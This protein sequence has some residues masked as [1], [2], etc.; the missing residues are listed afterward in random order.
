MNRSVRCSVAPSPLLLVSRFRVCATRRFQGKVQYR[1]PGVAV[2]SKSGPS[3]AQ[4]GELGMAVQTQPPANHPFTRLPH[5]YLHTR[6]INSRSQC[7]KD[8]EDYCYKSPF[9]GG[10][11]ILRYRA[12]GGPAPPS[13]HHHSIIISVWK[14]DLT[15]RARSS[16]AAARRSIS[17]RSARGGRERS[18]EPPHLSVA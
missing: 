16:W 5:R 9:P 14:G 11:S 2:G 13:A 10:S 7:R 8:L 18:L 6:S 12:A 4:G 15:E 1:E 17:A 3:A